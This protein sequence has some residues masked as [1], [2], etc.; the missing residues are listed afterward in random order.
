MNTSNVPSSK[1]IRLHN[2][3]RFPISLLIIF[4]ILAVL[5][6]TRDWRRRYRPIYYDANS[7]RAQA[8]VTELVN[9]LFSATGWASDAPQNRQPSRRTRSESDS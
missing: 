8:A 5:V 9:R 3:N 4:A 1:R 2:R 6:E 7:R